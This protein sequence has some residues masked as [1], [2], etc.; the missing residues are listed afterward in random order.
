MTS[1]CWVFHTFTKLI[2]WLWLEKNN[3]NRQ[4]V[5][6]TERRSEEC[7]VQCQIFLTA[8]FTTKAPMIKDVQGEVTGGETLIN[9]RGFWVHSSAGDHYLSLNSYQG[10][11]HPLEKAEASCSI[12]WNPP[13]RYVVLGLVQQRGHKT[14]W[15]RGPWGQLK[16]RLV[17]LTRPA[18]QL[19]A[20]KW[21]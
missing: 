13:S 11:L 7:H 16:V 3:N 19:I 20:D 4:R 10:E 2:I 6:K 8:T 1:L 17:S 21:S 15:V 18:D 14:P 5:M 12:F 9:A